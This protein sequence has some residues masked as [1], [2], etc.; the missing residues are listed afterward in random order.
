M[1]RG[2]MNDILRT[3]RASPGFAIAL[4][5]TLAAAAFNGLAV[6]QPALIGG[7]IDMSEV[8]F[9]GGDHRTHDLVFG[10]L[11]L[12]AVVG[13]LAQFRRPTDNVAG[14]L[15]ALIPS[16]GLLLT[17]LVTIVMG[18]TR[19]LQPPWVTVMVA[20]LIAIV[21]HPSGADFFRSFRAA[22]ADRAMVVL[23]GVAAV[24]L[25]TL[26][27]TDVGRQGAVTDDHAALGHYGFM[28]AFA[29]TIIGVG[30]LAGF[31]PDG[32]RPVAWLAGLLPILLGTTSLW[33]PD[34]VSSLGPVWA[35]VAIAWGVAFVATAE[36]RRSSR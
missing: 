33:Y 3:L 13:T 4:V 24:P 30:L 16:V 11:F 10:F 27:V 8:H 9:V 18:N 32:W 12:P 23:V 1:V 22:R 26:F 31:R 25:L 7:V 29:L 15:M 36:L 35:L 14:Q 6:F 2:G 20:V 28:A 17:L 21:L 19:V 5:L 34:A